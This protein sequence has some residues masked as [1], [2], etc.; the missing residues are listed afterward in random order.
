[1]NSTTAARQIS[2][3]VIWGA[4]IKRAS[5]FNVL[6]STEIP[7]LKQTIG[8]QMPGIPGRKNKYCFKIQTED[9]KWVMP[10]EKN[11]RGQDQRQCTKNAKS[12]TIPLLGNDVSKPRR[13][14]THNA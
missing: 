12:R 14:R 9:E 1:M 13:Q 6:C 10:A 7:R 3:Q 2:G 4:E 5:L 8:I 11:W